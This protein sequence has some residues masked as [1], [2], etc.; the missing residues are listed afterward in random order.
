VLEQ[1][2]QALVSLQGISHALVAATGLSAPAV[3]LCQQ[4]RDLCGAD[5]AV[6][7][8]LRPGDTADILAIS[9]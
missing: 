4:A 1:R 8:Y 3:R 6:L 7:Y 5:R 9:G 2:T